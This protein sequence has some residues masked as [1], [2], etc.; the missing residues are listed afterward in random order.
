MKVVS[1]EEK[2]SRPVSL[3]NSV[4]GAGMDRVIEKK[5]FPL[6][7]IAIAAAVVSGLAIIAWFMFDSSG[8]RSL[9]V[10]NSRIVISK[11]SRGVFEDFIPIR[12]QVTPRQTVYLDAIEGGRVEEKLIEDGAQVKAGDP[13]VVL[14]NTSL[15]LS[16]TQNEAMVTE[17]LNNMRTIELR[18]E[19]NRLQHKRNLVELDYQIQRLERQVSRLSNLDIAGLVVK[20]QL[21]DAED[22]LAY[23]RNR[24]DVTLESQ[25]TDARLQETQLQF[26][27]KSGA[28]LE[29]NLVFA[30]KNLDALN[31]R[32]P[33]D[34][35]L[36]GLDLEVGQ[37]IQR[38]GRL[39]QI[40]DPDNFKLRAS[41][42]EFYLN[43][44]GIGQSANFERGG[45]RYEMRVSKIYPQVKNGQFEIDL[46]FDGDQP[47]G[48]R[49]GQTIQAK[50]TL[51]DATDALLIPN[52]AFFQDTGGNWMFV[53]NAAG[54]EAVKRNVRLGR[55][56]SRNIEVLEGLEQGE[57]VVTSPYSSFREMD[58][59]KLNED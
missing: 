41:I 39:G 23:Y 8:G 58:R 9:V 37:S 22:E 24:R 36:S 57:E 11:V 31:V 3:A 26:L 59:L 20:S 10:D 52:G 12:G 38:G 34:G 28:Q 13:I 18:L 40:D 4:S 35:K 2:S 17:Q 54:T 53:V 16:V 30:R 42:D 48:I 7:K 25:A 33:V 1:P 46:L 6:Q 32:A 50:L 27:Q 43:R 15:Q 5:K 44:V 51:G 21:E 55:R 45:D 29:Q 47:E 14:S 56:N 19:Q 49:R